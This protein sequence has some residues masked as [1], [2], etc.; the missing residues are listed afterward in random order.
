MT[1]NSCVAEPPASTSQITALPP[2]WLLL[3]TLNELFFLIVE[4][5]ESF[6]R[7]L[8]LILSFSKQ[9]FFLFHSS[10]FIG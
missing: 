5:E 6:I 1:F 9:Y 3:F 4:F 8:L 2:L 7:C 10:D